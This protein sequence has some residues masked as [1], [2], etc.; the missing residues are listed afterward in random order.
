MRICGVRH[1][2][3]V[4]RRV[5]WRL[6]PDGKPIV[7]SFSPTRRQK[8]VLLA[9]FAF[10]FLP[11]LPA[12]AQSASG[13]QEY[14][15]LGHEEH[16][17]N[18][19]DRVRQSEAATAFPAPN[20]MNSVVSVTSTSDGQIV[21]YDHWEDGFE[22]VIATP[23]Q[24]TTMVLGDGN[25]LNGRVCDWSKDPRVFPCT[26]VGSHDDLLYAGTPMAFASD[27]GMLGACAAP[28]PASNAAPPVNVAQIR[29]SVPVPRSVPAPVTPTIRFDGGDRVFNTGGSLSIAH[30]QDP[31][32]PL[33]GGGTELISRELVKEAV[34]YSI[35]IGENLFPGTVNAFASV[36]YTS[37]DIVAFDDNTQVTV[38]SPAAGT[39]SFTLH[40]GQHFSTCATFTPG[41]AGLAGVSGTCTAGAIDGAAPPSGPDN[42]G[43]FPALA[44]RVNSGTKVSTTGPLNILMFTGGT[45]EYQTRHYATL[46]D[47]L[48]TSDYVLTAPGDDPAAGGSRG[49]NLYIYNPNPTVTITVNTVDSVGPATINIGPNSVVDYRN[50]VGRFVPNDSTVRLTSTR[51]FWGVSA[52]GIEN[53][54]SDW[55]HSWLGVRFLSTDYTLAYSPGTQ[56]YPVTGIACAAG[57]AT[58]TTTIGHEFDNGDRIR[59]AGAVPAG[60]NGDFIIA[61]VAATTFTYAV[62][63]CP[64][65]AATGVLSA[66]GICDVTDADLTGGCDSY[67]RDPVWVSGTQ[68]NTQ[69]RIDRNADGIFDFVDINSDGCPDSGDITVAAG[70]CETPPTFG[71]TAG[72]GT[73]TAPTA[74]TC[75]YVVNAPGTAGRDTLRVWDYVD[76]DNAGTRIVSTKPVAVSWGQDTDQGEGS[77][78]SPDNGYTVYPEIAVDT[79]LGLDKTVT[80]ARVP[81]G[82]TAGQRTASYTLRIF[83]GNYGPVNNVTITDILPSGIACADFVAGSTLVTYP[84]LTQNSPVPTCLPTVAP[85]PLGRFKLTWLLSTNSL[86]IDQQILVTYSVII[87]T[88]ASSRTLTNDAKTT[89]NLGGSFFTAKDTAT[90]TQTNLSIVK[91]VTP[92]DAIPEVGDTLSYSIVVTNGIAADGNVTIIDPLPPFTTLVG[93]SIN[94][95]APFTGSYSAAQNAVVWSCAGAAC[96][97]ANATATLT[98]QVTINPATP[99]GSIIPNAG[100]YSSN[101]VPSLNTNEVQT[102]VQGPLLAIT[103]SGPPG[104]LHPNEVA[105]FSVTVNNN[106]SGAAPGVVLTD[107]LTGSNTTY[108]PGTMEFSLN[109]GSFTALTDA[110]DADGGT[111]TGAT[112]T[113]TLASLGAGGDLVFRFKARVNAGT[114]GQ[115][116]TNQAQVTPSGQPSIDSNLVQIPIVGNATLTGRVFLDYDGDGVQDPGEPGA[117]GVPVLVTDSTG[118]TQT[119]FTNANG[120]YIATVPAGN[121]TINPDQTGGNIPTGAVLTTGNDPQTINAVANATTNVP[122]VGYDPP[123]LSIVK[124]SDGGGTVAPGETVT[125]T[126]QVTNN[127]P[128]RQTGIRV[129]DSLPPNVTYVAA[130]ANVKQSRVIRATEY[131]VAAG[132]F[133]GTTF[134]LALNQPLSA[135]Y[136]VIVQGSDTA[137]NTPPS[138]NYISLT[139]DP[140]A[141]GAAGAQPGLANSG[142]ASAIGFTR[143]ASA[144]G[145]SW[146]GV[147]TV[148][149]CLRDC[150]VNGFQLRD[151]ARITHAGAGVGPTAVASDF[152]WTALTRLMLL[153]GFQGAGC[154][155]ADAQASDAKSCHTRIF[156][157]GTGAASNINWTRDVGGATSLEAATSTVMV[158]EWGSAWTQN[159]ATITA[160]NNGGAGVDAVAEYNVSAAFPA[161]ARQRTWVWGT[162]HTNDNEQAQAA[163]GVALALGNGVNQNATETTVAAGLYVNNN[164]VNYEIYALTHPQ[165]SVAHAFK[166]E[167][168][169]TDPAALTFTVA[170]PAATS[171]R[172]AIG[173]SGTGQNDNLYPASMFSNRYSNPSQFTMERTQAGTAG[174]GVAAWLQGIDFGSI[175]PGPAATITCL[176]TYPPAAQNCTTPNVNANIVDPVA[177]FSLDPGETMTV[178]FQVTVNLNAPVGTLTNTAEGDSN[179]E[180]PVQDPASDT[181]VIPGV[182]VEPNG[183]G[184]TAPGT[185]I[186]FT[187]E[188]V[189]RGTAVDSFNVTLA[190]QNGWKVELI[191]PTSGGIIATDTNGDGVWDGGVTINTGALAP[192]AGTTYRVRITVPPGT[193]IGTQSTTELKAIS[194]ASSLYSAV[195]TDEVTV[196]TSAQFGPVEVIADQSGVANA[197]S[198]VA[199][200][201]TILNNT[202]GVATFSLTATG[203][204]SWTRTIHA[205]SNG[206]GLYTP[207]VDLQITNTASLLNGGSQRVFVVENVPPGTA[208]G[209]VD[210]TV[211]NAISTTNATHYDSATL[212]TRVQ[213]PTTLDL[214]GGGSRVV[215]PGDTAIY[216]GVAYNLTGSAD[217]FNFTLTQASLFGFDGLNHP[218]QLWFDTNGDKTPDTLVATDTDGNGT[219]NTIAP[220]FDVDGNGKPDFL[221]GA[222]S[223]LD[224]ELRRV[225]D[226]AQVFPTE[227]VTLGIQSTNT[228]S[229]NDAVTALWIIANVTRASI[230]GL[231]VDTSNGIVEFATGTQRHTRSFNIYETDSRQG[232]SW[233]LLTPEPIV[234]PFADSEFPIL[235][236][237]ETLAITKRFIVIEETETNG[238]KLVKGPFSIRDARLKRGLETVEARLNAAGVPPG[239]IRIGKTS[240]NGIATREARK[241]DRRGKGASHRGRALRGA[242]DAIRIEI[243]EPGVIRIPVRDLE[244]EGLPNGR[245][246]KLW[247]RGVAVPFDW[248]NNRTEI[249]FVATPLVS[250]YSDKNVY[251]VTW[252]GDRPYPMGVSLTASADAPRPGYRRIERDT[253]YFPATPNGADPWVWDAVMSNG[254]WWPYAAWDPE[255]ASGRFDLPAYQPPSSVV[256]IRIRV[257][258]GTDHTHTVEAKISG[259]TVGSVTF[260]GKN[261]GL[262]SGTLPASVLKATGNQLSLV[263]SAVDGA[264]QEAESGYVFLDYVDVG[265]AP[266][267]AADGV[268]GDVSAYSGALPD[269]RR[270][271]YLI[272]T[273]PDFR[274]A[275]DR[276]AALKT[277]S[278]LKSA[279]VETDELYDRFSGG[280][281]EARAIQKGIRELAGQSGRLKYVLL[282]GDDTFDTRNI[283]GVGETAFVPSLFGRDEGFGRIP[284]ENLYAD[285]DDDGRPDIAIGRLAAKSMADAD[286]L[287]DKV[288]NGPQLLRQ[289]LNAQV[290]ATDNQ[291]E[292]DAPFREEA[293]EMAGLS[294]ASLGT[295][296]IADVSEGTSV[297]R[298]NLMR[299]WKAGVSQV[300]Y[301]GHGGPELWADESLLTT[302]D[303]EAEGLSLTPAVVFMWACESQMYQYL[304]GPSMGEKLMLTPNAGAVASFGPVGIA[305]PARQRVLYQKVYSQLLQGGETLGEI[306]RKAKAAAILEKPGAADVVSGFN[307]LGDP[308]LLIPKR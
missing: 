273:H 60:F 275:A 130:S 177:G 158:V 64:A 218:T 22:P 185:T 220:G 1:V 98:F 160:G 90:V 115:F 54:V 122:F 204:Q 219:W 242:R 222:N 4:Q 266:S 274:A 186:T 118:V 287:V 56:V 139:S 223:T 142:G 154:N 75:V 72:L 256:P 57:T 35:P 117:V 33:I 13:F 18:M 26:G 106:G 39:V 74:N 62:A 151:V 2:T 267:S 199:Y 260:T 178:T 101:A 308:A 246:I 47:I 86:L 248:A 9:F 303:I 181:I 261:K 137:A 239:A 46:P 209:T 254:Q 214:S 213:A 230:R 65:A 126:I 131:V 243:D 174:S 145:Q 99:T 196:L 201:M 272:V 207:G 27:L 19:M 305:A 183:A 188:V 15:V 278:G 133:T 146:A 134:G 68:N 258:G 63:L 208:A 180:T 55:G 241:R 307:L 184:F 66:V 268:V 202:G 37:L 200:P 182:S 129:T 203:T 102:V 265:A 276:V 236:R 249:R 193:A 264:G 43:V 252:N 103:K 187:H 192:G 288:A 93:G 173:Y 49:L 38:N 113:F 16:V 159:R 300:H 58:V 91:S 132:S 80:P 108:E 61:G 162:G 50:A 285:L 198:F 263:E 304:W 161:V 59:I 8:C 231:R 147:I 76:M 128:G 96:F 119:V 84:D 247:N 270:V 11:S 94:S 293:A 73:C 306:L 141:T 269:V 235:Y 51:P 67:N 5:Q 295:V 136:F 12:L 114:G 168:T 52:Y 29:C 166:A 6:T 301:F 87:P 25:N 215:V 135:N 279:V 20:R 104:P 10:S 110:G 165:L 302:D 7:H 17:W 169:A 262:I 282:V 89:G 228:P 79:V 216:P 44:L 299:A 127:S 83:A 21:T 107:N 237:V 172:M 48:H 148:V 123:G 36:K 244:M 77:D 170:T 251:V 71:P 284:S 82:G 14:F 23:V 232:D 41:T 259:V 217:R 283:T 152:Q 290:Y 271:Q 112:L 225:I 78:P 179:E 69:V 195:G 190:Q 97:A 40:R 210:V 298:A 226:A 171:S 157:S 28:H 81:L 257:I 296:T 88:T 149:E 191:E 124:T 45:G 105:L 292:N 111:I 85:D 156:P 233:R 121:T 155:T 205:D 164:A 206:D 109:G 167:N 277:A 227:L 100:N 3:T 31:G 240:P 281:V 150:A 297:A 32:T 176:G 120:D 70:I 291:G 30:I 138:R 189:N 175:T 212:T 163:E 42:R 286:V 53:N 250:D 92:Q 294:G 289:F 144:V 211:L 229:Q 140:F 197:G 125:Y 224:Y 143:G 221:V 280:I 24:S 253:I 34:S 194:V 234:T 245:S 116:A 255:G 95:P 153:G 238:N